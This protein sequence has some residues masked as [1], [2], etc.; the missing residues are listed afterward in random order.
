VGTGDA[1][2]RAVR[3]YGPIV[4]LEV[5]R[6]VA[7]PAEQVWDLLVDTARWPAWGPT[8]AGAEVLAG[9]DGTRIGPG[10]RGRVRTSLGPTLPFEV[11]AFEPGRRWTWAV[12]GVPATGHRVEPLGPGRCRVTFEVP[13][14]A[15]P[16]LLVCRQALVRIERLATT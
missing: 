15:A 7:A 3:R 8:V 1:S 16:Y 2:E 13:T 5:G 12:A 9:A 10:A 14:W 6:E 11:R 4:G